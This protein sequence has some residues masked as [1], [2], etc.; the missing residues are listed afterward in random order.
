M[1]QVKTKFRLKFSNLGWF[2]ISCL[3]LALN[4]YEL[5]LGDK[6]TWESY[7]DK[8]FFSIYV[9]LILTCNISYTSVNIMSYS[10]CILCFV[11]SKA[12]SMSSL[13][14]FFTLWQSRWTFNLQFINK[15]NKFTSTQREN[16][17]DQARSEGRCDGCAPPPPPRRFQRST[18]SVDQRLKQSEF[19]VLF[20]S[21]SLIV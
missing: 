21:N 8:T 9:N 14:M 10:N 13:L 17:W 3:L 16:L 12:Q 18:F 1:S 2:S 7:W 5:V 15:K 20:Y 4:I 6:E 11:R 19:R